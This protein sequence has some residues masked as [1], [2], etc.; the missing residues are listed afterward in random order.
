M[1]EPSWKQLAQI[2]D[3]VLKQAVLRALAIEVP[4]AGRSP[5]FR[6]RGLYLQVSGDG[7]FLFMDSGEPRQESGAAADA[8]RPHSS[9]WYPDGSSLLKA[10]RWPPGTPTGDAIR[11][12]LRQ[13][14]WIPASE[15]LQPCPQQQGQTS[16]VMA[17]SLPSLS[18]C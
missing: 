7:G 4:Q 15:S 3:G 10:I 2:P 11:S 16:T 14:G 6:D 1:A 13:W 12:W 9:R 8:P 5:V 17:R 18:N